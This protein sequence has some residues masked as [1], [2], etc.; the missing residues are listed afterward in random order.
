[1]LYSNASVYICIL[2]SY[3]KF[4][5]GCDKVSEVPFPLY[6]RIMCE[7]YEI[8]NTVTKNRKIDKR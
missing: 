5:Y 2:K 7:M 8:C 6:I 3:Y 4:K 1:M